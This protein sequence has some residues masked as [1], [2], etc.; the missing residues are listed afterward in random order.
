VRTT[1]RLSDELNAEWF[2][3]H[4]NLTSKPELNPANVERAAK[5]M[6]LAEEL[7]ARTRTLTG[8]SIPETVLAYAK[9]HNVTKIVV[10]KPNH[11]RWMEMLSGSIVDQ[12]IYASGD[13]DIYVINEQP[14]LKPT[15]ISEEL[16]PHQPFRR[17]LFAV[18]MVVLTTF[19][20]H[21]F[22]LSW[23]LLI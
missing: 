23:S 18:F 11:P 19:I 16:R 5:T 8:R 10:G 7:G 3:V 22:I 17:Y 6:Q 20:G 15:K 12:L 4:V 13:I 21:F 14:D 2:A 9:K 1:R